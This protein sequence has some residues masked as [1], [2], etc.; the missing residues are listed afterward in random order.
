MCCELSLH[1][2]R[3]QLVLN[4]QQIAYSYWA[5]DLDIAHAVQLVTSVDD[6]YDTYKDYGG[7]VDIKDN[8]QVGV[9]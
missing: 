8:V 7:K 4:G 6:M 1:V 2:L 9:L 3:A 5:V